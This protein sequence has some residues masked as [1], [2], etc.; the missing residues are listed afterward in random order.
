[1]FKSLLIRLSSYYGVRQDLVRHCGKGKACGQQAENVYNQVILGIYPFGAA[2]MTNHE[3]PRHQCR[4]I[5]SSVHTRVRPLTSRTP[6]YPV[7]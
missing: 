5:P 1:M 2:S 3:F 7:N 6:D 4:M